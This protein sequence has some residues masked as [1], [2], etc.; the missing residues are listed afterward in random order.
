MSPHSSFSS[1]VQ[2]EV[3]QEEV[4]INHSERFHCGIG[5]SL[6]TIDEKSKSELET[7]SNASQIMY[8]KA[9]E[10]IVVQ[11][12]EELSVVSS[13]ANR[14]IKCFMCNEYIFKRDA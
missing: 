10:S 8:S 1:S 4:L 14:E 2:S 3:Y 7:M 5:G 11:E 9:E 12:E 6:E 13:S